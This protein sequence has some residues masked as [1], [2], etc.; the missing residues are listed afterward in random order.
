MATLKFKDIEK[1]NLEERSKKMQEMKYELVKA[2]TNAAKSGTS[3][4]KEIKKIIARILTLNN[5][6][7]KVKVEEK[8]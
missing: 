4:A 7:S 8:K 5:K 2:K 6:E 1:M 3:K